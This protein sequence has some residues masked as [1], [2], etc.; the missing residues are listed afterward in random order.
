[1]TCSWGVSV[2]TCICSCFVKIKFVKSQ[3]GVAFYVV[4]L[5]KIALKLRRSVRSYFFFIVRF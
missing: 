4:H 1:M 3:K 5:S 2:C